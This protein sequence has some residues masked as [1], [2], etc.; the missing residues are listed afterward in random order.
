MEVSELK[1]G[2]YPVSVRQRTDLVCAVFSWPLIASMT[3]LFILTVS[4]GITFSF[5]HPAEST[6]FR[7]G[8]NNKMFHSGMSDYSNSSY[9]GVDGKCQPRCD[10]ESFLFYCL[11]SNR[12]ELKKAPLS[13]R[14]L[15]DASQ[16]FWFGVLLIVLAVVLAFPMCFC[17]GKLAV[18]IAHV[19]TVLIVGVELV[20][21]ALL[22]YI[23]WDYSA[24]SILVSAAL[25]L[26]YVFFVRRRL[27]II[28]PL[29]TS[30][31]KVLMK[32]KT[33][34]LVPFLIITLTGII[35]AVSGFGALM[36]LGLGTPDAKNGY[37]L[38]KHKSLSVTTFVFPLCGVW[39]SE[40]FVVWFRSAIALIIS[41]YYFRH[42]VPS[43]KTALLELIKYH[44]GT[45]TFGSFA[46]FLLENI[47]LFFQFI[48]STMSRTQNGFVKFLCK[49]IM[50]FAFCLIQFVGEINRLSFVFT[51]M[52]GMSFWSG[53]KYAAKTLKIDTMFSVDMLLHNIF[54]S[55]R[56]VIT[57]AA[58]MATYAYAQQLELLVPWIPLAAIPTAVYI[59]L[60]AIDVT[61]GTSSE[62]ILMCLCEDAKGDGIYTPKDLEE[63]LNWLREKVTKNVFEA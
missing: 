44:S 33:L 30:S 14:A 51:A 11:S 31:F 17:V 58:A 16:Y 60:S 15:Y 45:F 61:L 46:V 19:S 25:Y 39:L 47:S 63:V 43:L 10:G 50:M 36:S 5:F 56:V 7:C 8:I 48:N 28:A 6:G 21:A 24:S 37:R 42:P 59:A 29:M 27:H 26:V 3:V 22:Y 2:R 18:V 23:G 40:F 9:L 4:Y 41:S 54:F 38:V 57:F 53:C 32:E 34:F 49:C 62:A 20:I 55:V 12:K 52:K 1:P 13:V 35:A